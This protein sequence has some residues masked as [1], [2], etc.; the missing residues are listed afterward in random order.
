ML[1]RIFYNLAN[2]HIKVRFYIHFKFQ[3]YVGRLAPVWKNFINFVEFCHVVSHIS[4]L[5]LERVCTLLLQ[6]NIQV[7]F[8]VD[9][10]KNSRF[11]YNL[12]SLKFFA[13]IYEYLK[14]FRLQVEK[15]LLRQG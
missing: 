10:L 12:V 2:F 8:D 15:S 11:L 5:W 4:S 6:I 3:Y 7:L 1:V 13:H 14:E 9:G